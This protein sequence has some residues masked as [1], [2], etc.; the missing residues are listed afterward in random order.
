MIV[1]YADEISIDSRN[2][3]GAYFAMTDQLVVQ[4]IDPVPMEAS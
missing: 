1:E 3:C 4:V 2:G